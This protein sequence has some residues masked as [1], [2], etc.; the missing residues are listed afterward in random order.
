MGTSTLKLLAAFFMLC[1]HIVVYIPYAPI[2]LD[3]IGRLSFPLYVFCLAWGID[4]TRNIK[5]YRLRLYLAGAFM[6]IGSYLLN[7]SFPS[8]RH[9]ISENIFPTLFLIVEMVSFLKSFKN[10]KKKTFPYLLLFSFIQVFSVFCYKLILENSKVSALLFLAIVP[11]ILFCEGSIIFVL[12]GVA[13]YF[14]K[15][16]RELFI[17]IYIS[18]SFLW[19]ILAGFNGFNYQSFFVYQY[20]WMMIAAL[21]LML[22]F[23]KK[24]RVYISSIFFY[25][26]YPLHIYILF[27]MQKL[28]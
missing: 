27:I 14:I 18:F 3:W 25:L 19:L 5:K 28:F 17:E 11:N 26:F 15:N 20:Q 2:W 9:P 6:G 4:Y 12:F 1:S 22:H 13:I 7:I 16:N 8:L 24:E 21:P 23:N 10:D